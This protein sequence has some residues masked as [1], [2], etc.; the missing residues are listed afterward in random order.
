MA[1]EERSGPPKEL[2]CGRLPADRAA[3]LE[4]ALQTDAQLADDALTFA[5]RDVGTRSHRI[6][7]AQRH[8]RRQAR[9]E[10]L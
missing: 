1:D 9:H 10:G 8:Y 4:E 5:E 6:L 7:A 3:T 2:V